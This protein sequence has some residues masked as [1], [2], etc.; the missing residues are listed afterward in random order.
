MVL[1]VAATCLDGNSSLREAGICRTPVVHVAK[2]VELGQVHGA[3]VR[4][5]T[6]FFLCCALIHCVPQLHKS[7]LF[8]SIV[9]HVV[10]PPTVRHCSP[11]AQ[12]LH[13]NCDV[14]HA[15]GISFRA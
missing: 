13:H 14:S 9:Q 5:A 12:L 3:S 10:V 15:G 2:A 7:F 8:S 6:L 4:Q 1:H 11:T